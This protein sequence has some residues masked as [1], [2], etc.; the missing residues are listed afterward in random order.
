MF[1]KSFSRWLHRGARAVKRNRNNAKRREQQGKLLCEVLEDRTLPAGAVGL[2][3]SILPNIV[4]KPLA[5]SPTNIVFNH[6]AGSPDNLTPYAIGYSPGQIEQAYG[7]N[8]ITDNGVTMNG[9]GQTIAIVDAYDDPNILLDLE[10][11]D[12]W[13]GIP[14]P[15]SFTK[16]VP[17]GVT[18]STDPTGSWEAEE[19]LDVEYAHALAP[20]A[21][22]VFVEANAGANLFDTI[23]NLISAANWA[24]Q[25]SGA[26]VVSM[27]WGEPESFFASNGVNE[28]SYD[29][30]FA[31]PSGHRVTFV[32]ATGDSGAP[33]AYPAYSP[34]VLAVGGTALNLDANGNYSSET[35][36]SLLSDLQN[37]Y[38]ASGGGVS[39]Y[40]PQP[41]YQKGLINSSTRT[42]P[43]VAFDADPNTG[44]P[45]F[46]SFGLYNSY[47]E[48][49]SV[50]WMGTGGTSL[51]TPCWAA[52]ISIA[53][54]IR[55]DHG[56][57]SLDGPSQTLP[58][59]YRLFQNPTTYARDFHDIK[60]GNNGYPAGTGYDLVTG[61]G[62][63]IAN[64]LVPDLAGITSSASQL[65]FGQQPTNVQTGQAINPE[66]T[67]LVEDS[68]GNVVTTDNSNV[69]LTIGTNPSGGTLSG[70]LTVA[71]VNGVATFSDLSINQAGTGYTLVASDGSL[72][73]ATSSSF[74]ITPAPAKVVFTIQPSN[75]LAGN[76]MTPAVQVTVEDANGNV[77]T[78]DNSNVTLTIG[79]NPSGGT[80]SGT[81]TV[82][83]VNGVATFS[84][85]SIDQA[86]TGYTLAASDGSLTGTTSSSF[87]ISTL[88]PPSLGT[89]SLVEG[90][91]SGTDSDLVVDG[92]SWSAT[93]N[94]S[95][96]HTTSSGTGNG[97][98]VFTFDANSGA[99][100]SGTLT[101]AGQT[102]T[103][104]QAGSSYVPANSVSN[105]V[106]GLSWPEGVAVDGSGN[107]FFA[108]T[109]NH[110][111]KEWNATTG[112][113]STLAS[114]LQNPGGVAVDGAGIVYFSDYGNNTLEEWN[115]TTHTV[116]TLVST[117]LD[118]PYGL[119]VDGAGNVYIADFNHNAIDEWNATT[120]TLSTLVSGLNGPAFV[121]VDW[122]GNLFITDQGTN[123]VMEWNAKTLTVSTLVSGLNGPTGVAADSAGNVF[124][125]DLGSN[126]IKEWNATTQTVSTL[127]SGLNVP[128]GVA[129]DGAGNIYIG[130]S[131]NNAIKELSRAF[132]PDG[133]VSEGAA[134]GSDQL[135]PVLPT[136]EALTGA[137]AP[138]SDQTWLT[139]GSVSGGVISFSFTQ[140]TGA[141]RTAHITVFGQQVTVTQAV[142]STT[143]P[144][145]V[146]S[147]TA[148]SITST[149]AT[150]GGTVSSD[151]GASLSKRGVLY[152][153]T[154]VNSNPTLGGT[155]VKEADDASTST[156][157]FTEAIT[158]LTAGAGYSYVA[159]ATNSAGTSYTSP[160]ST[161]VTLS[162]S[163]PK[164]DVE[165]IATASPNQD[166][167]A[168]LPL[169]VSSIDVGQTF[170]VE[171]WTKD[172]DGSSNGI[173][174]GDV[175]FS[176]N[177]S[178]VTAGTISHGGIFNNLE[179]KTTVS[180]GQLT[181]LGGGAPLGDLGEGTSGWVRLG[182]VEFTARA[183]GSAPFT[184]SPGTSDPFGRANEGS[185][186]WSDVT[187]N[188]TPLSLAINAWCLYDPAHD[189]RIDSGD[190]SLLSTDWHATPT[191]PNWNGGRC[192]FA[193]DGIVNSGDFSWF[194]SNWHKYDNDPTITYPPTNN[195]DIRMEASPALLGSVTLAATPSNPEIDVELVPVATP[196]SSDQAVSLPVALSSEPVGSTFYVEVWIENV[197]GSSNGITYG[198]VNFSF[199]PSLI[200]AGT[201]SHGGIFANLEENTTVS[202]G[203]VTDLGG[204]APLG[205]L[206]EGT[207]GWVRLGYV[208]F[209]ANAA[210]SLTFTASP[211]SSDPF[212]RA[213]E[214]SVP[215]SDVEM[216]VPKA[217]VYLQAAPI[218]SVNPVAINYGTALANSQL[219]GTAT[220]TV[221]GNPV[222]VAGTFSYT[223]A[224][225]TVLGAGSGQSEDVTFTPSDSTDYTTA[226]GN[227]TVNVA[228]ATS[229]ISV[230]PVVIID[231]T[232]LA[233]SQL[234]GTATWTVNGSP[235]TV[236]GTF[237]Y[238]SAA[239]TVLALVVARV[240]T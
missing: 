60:T 6:L 135:L 206:G 84:D 145:T 113:V 209:T 204:G 96:L 73:G 161:F 10:Y 115:A 227:V 29:S 104:T 186:P 124:F 231:G 34:N 194:S 132:V 172:V 103:V 43:D 64:N 46:D 70:T 109:G 218:I 91:V 141:A 68:N 235:V 123:T 111:I 90:P 152:A 21:N 181:D 187:M 213:N 55:A 63:P 169:S 35:G 240:K 74:N 101:I 33:G 79:T 205:D 78:T 18:P 216:N 179:E 184:A 191:S 44:V 167:S 239:G 42:I 133:T 114:G 107:V 75:T 36:W 157:T 158:G 9:A 185:V 234:S 48:L 26:S 237:S 223:S 151:A 171:V 72:T 81:L 85:L 176:F 219:S 80:L 188:G 126:A 199:N 202:N 87:N 117:G 140:N 22:I 146:T 160:V 56:L 1:P 3:S 24:G 127:V 95:W 180:T 201:V 38:A 175:N 226:Y 215:W 162:P 58:T 7:I 153:L 182:Y 28:N 217:T 192:D 88:V 23:N 228:Q 94:V 92:G 76:T 27:S 168:T 233:N 143:A 50:D 86:G 122:A 163:T 11:F 32:A 170:Y 106:S 210:G 183:A 131:K 45:I 16:I 120:Q 118:F 83:A 13:Y 173:T 230:N 49:Q 139:I 37:L 203:Q 57:G 198:D 19:S 31:S 147:P 134:A 119:A 189:G 238:T 144:P 222:T 47:G 65:V 108:D 82:A 53:D 102:L 97:L 99:T 150:L 52:L 121:A 129:V 156:G 149:S 166:T 61:I 232:A 25:C 178:L 190:Y 221:N 62:S 67:V 212:G 20:G 200:T 174:Y 155:G 177:A 5:E 159:F 98:A 66:V 30:L 229:I 105:L 148:T 93:S 197:D 112:T 15:P 40:E 137:F 69:T 211:G 225:G 2:S 207:S 196:T 41:A 165:L 220:W 128:N 138:S 195:G 100:R 17:N 14:N 208:E 89:I 39:N 4:Y 125:A 116:S 142:G 54:E 8:K 193:N 71:A 77:V 164:I 12:A 110:A 51:A 59:L 236:A 154:S 136:T 214:G 130:D 224:A